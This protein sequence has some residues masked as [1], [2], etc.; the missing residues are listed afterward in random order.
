MRCIDV[1][2]DIGK[3]VRKEAG[4]NPKHI[5]VHGWIDGLAFENTL[6]PRGG[7]NFRFHLNSKIWR[8][9][10]IDA[11]AAVEV[12]MSLDSEPREA[13]DSARPRRGAR[14]NAAC[15]GRVHCDHSIVAPPSCGLDRQSE[16]VQNAR[17]A[18]SVHRKENDRT[19]AKESSGR[20]REKSNRKFLFT[21]CLRRLEMPLWRRFGL[22]H[23]SFTVN[24]QLAISIDA[25]AHRP[26]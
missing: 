5:P 18:H 11:G 14:R 26:R 4:G 12:T 16:A 17:Q 21:K 15:A 6:V 20:K 25:R 23:S 19:R 13:V 8:K 10:Q 7:G 22:K 9:L 2:R 3:A 24:I 1:P